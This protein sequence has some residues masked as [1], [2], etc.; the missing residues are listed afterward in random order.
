MNHVIWQPSSIWLS[1]IGAVPSAVARF[2]FKRICDSDG[3]QIVPPSTDTV[4]TSDDIPQSASVCDNCHN[5]FKT[6]QSLLFHQR[7]V[8][9]DVH[10]PDDWAPGAALARLLNWKGPG[11]GLRLRAP[12]K[13]HPIGSRDRP[14][15][16]HLPW[17][18]GGQWG[19]QISPKTKWNLQD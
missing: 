12:P 15:K 19:C 14:E 5:F 9:G 13:T 4:A 2:G 3:A 18:S 16:E 1:I 6:R 8:H 17:S 10:V 7:H 11:R